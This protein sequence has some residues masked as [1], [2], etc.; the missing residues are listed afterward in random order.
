MRGSRLNKKG[1]LS[2]FCQLS[3][4]TLSNITFT[5]SRTPRARPAPRPLSVQSRRTGQDTHRGGTVLLPSGVHSTSLVRAGRE[6][7]GSSRA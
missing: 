7:V 3:L 5:P 1:L 4:G 6:G 2:A